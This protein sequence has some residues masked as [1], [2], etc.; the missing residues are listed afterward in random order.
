MTVATRIPRETVTPDR[1]AEIVDHQPTKPT[2]VTLAASQTVH[3]LSNFLTGIRVLLRSLS[4]DEPVSRQQIASLQEAALHAAELCEQL[5]THFAGHPSEP[6]LKVREIDVGAMVGAMGRLLEAMVPPGT[7]VNLDVTTGL[8]PIAANPTQLRRVVLDLLTNAA[9]ALGSEGGSITLRTGVLGHRD[10]AAVAEVARLRPTQPISGVPISGE[11]GE[12]ETYVFLEVADN[13]CGIAKDHRQRVFEPTF[14][15]KQHGHGLGLASVLEIVRGY[16]GAVTVDSRVG[17]GTRVRCIFP[18]ATW[19]PVEQPDFAMD[20]VDPVE[21]PAWQP[22]TILLVEDNDAAR[23]GSKL[24]LES[25]KPNGFHVLAAGTAQHAMNLL[26]DH[27]PEVSLVV[28]DA[29]LPDCPGEELLPQMRQVADELPVIVVSGF[30]E[31]QL[32]ARF[33]QAKPDSFLIKP[34]DGDALIEKITTLLSKNAANHA[35]TTRE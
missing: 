30:P 26:R 20:E 33:D 32:I 7:D 8:P 23:I 11:I 29:N 15:T 9:E 24:L 16:G 34:F 35:S 31:T 19:K 6:E 25:V 17:E 14:T 27:L 3:D 28:L 4:P 10:D 5:Q 18:S 13:G 1:A 22:T 12:G 21:G 2:P